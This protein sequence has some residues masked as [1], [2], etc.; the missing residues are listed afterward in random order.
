MTRTHLLACF[1]GLALVAGSCKEKTPN[2]DYYPAIK[3]RIVELQTAVKNR[4][5]SPLEKLLTSDYIALGGADSVVQF[6]FGTDPNSGFLS[7]SKAEIM[8]TNERARVDCVVMDSTGRELRPATFKFE[9]VDNAWLLKK[10][11]PQLPPPVTDTV[12][13]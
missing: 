9:H 2:R 5:E 7:Y 11:E 8:Y 6:S 12:K 10:I 13:E 4:D 3:A 1:V